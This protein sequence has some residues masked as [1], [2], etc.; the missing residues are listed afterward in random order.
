MQRISASVLGRSTPA[1]A[2]PPA[3]PTHHSRKQS[4]ALL[5]PSPSPAS[6]AHRR[7]HHRHQE[8]L[9]HRRHPPPVPPRRKSLRR[10]ASPLLFSPVRWI[11][12]LGFRLETPP[13][14]VSPTGVAPCSSPVSTPL[15]APVKWVKLVWI[16]FF[17]FQ[18]QCRSCKFDIKSNTWPKFTN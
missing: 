14:S 2:L 16:Q 5:T 1:L 17:K 6:L 13:E 10:W 11:Q 9:Q 18:I 15:S 3:S 7:P 12:S 8:L 4:T